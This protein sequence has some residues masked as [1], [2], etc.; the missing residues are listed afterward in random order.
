M[1]DRMRRGRQA[2]CRRGHLLPW[3]RAPSG[4]LLAPDH[5]RDPS[6][7]QSDPVKAAVV[8]PICAW[9]TDPRIPVR[10]YGVAKRLSDEPMPTPSGTAR[11]NV[12][13]VRGVLRSP[14]SAGTVSWGRP[15]PA[16]ARS[17]TSALQPVGPGE[18]HQPGPPEAWRAIPVP[19]IVSQATC[20]AAQARLDR[21]SPFARRNQTAHDTLLRGL[22]SWGQCLLACT[23]RPLPPGSHADRC[24]GRTD[25][26]RA[27]QGERWTARYTPARALDELVWHDR[28]RVLTAP[29]RITQA[30]QRAQGGAWLPQAFQ[31]RRQIL[32]EALAQRERQRNRL[33]EVSLADMIHRDECERQHKEGTQTPGS[34]SFRRGIA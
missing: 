10:R 2:T 21:Q 12:A 26:R 24:R 22:G 20:D 32:Q 6:R 29:M 25:A 13:S 4:S 34:F 30:L 33:L 14:A 3:S 19:A 28:C 31:A 7:G 18:R 1:A 17:R 27:A 23:G 16:P 5:P 9:D 8:T 11:W 15:R